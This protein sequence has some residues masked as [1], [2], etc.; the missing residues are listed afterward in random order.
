MASF[1]IL[2]RDSRLEARISHDGSIVH[3]YRNSTSE[4][5]KRNRFIGRGSYGTV[6]LQK[7][8]TGEPDVKIRVVK[9]IFIPDRQVAKRLD[10]SR[11]LEAIAKFSQPTVGLRT[12]DMIY[13]LTFH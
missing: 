3:K 7:C 2:V 8:V 5:W 4:H 11:E 9:E 13:A 12:L 6:W 10:Y 1:P